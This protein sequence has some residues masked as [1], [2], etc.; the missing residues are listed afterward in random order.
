MRTMRRGLALVAM[1]VSVF[2]T[3]GAADGFCGLGKPDIALAQ[4]DGTW[5]REGSVSVFNET[6]DELRPS[7]PFTVQISGDGTF[8]SPFVDSLTGKPLTVSVLSAPAYDVDRIDDVLDTTG[9]ADLAD[10][11]SDTLCGPSQLPQFQARLD[12]SDGISV[13]GTVT[14]IAYFADRVLQVS[15][16]ELKSEDTILFMTETVLLTP[17]AEK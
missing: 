6:T 10:A 5:K 4:I 16:L 11:V 9:R 13:S 15:E 8:V 14:L 12:V 3:S 17:Q 7:A 1:A 2:G